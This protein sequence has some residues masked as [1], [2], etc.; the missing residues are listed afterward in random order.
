MMSTKA[1]ESSQIQKARKK[2]EKQLQ[3]ADRK[4]NPDALNKMS[5]L[6]KQ[7]LSRQKPHRINLKK[8]H[9]TSTDEKEPAKAESKFVLRLMNQLKHEHTP[10][11][12]DLEGRIKPLPDLNK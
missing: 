9:I 2:I 3:A 5:Q 10:S 11:E 7:Q 6:I 1:K 4:I 8:R 12:K